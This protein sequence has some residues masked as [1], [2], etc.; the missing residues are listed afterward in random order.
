MSID[1]LKTCYYEFLSYFIP[2]KVKYR[3]EGE[4]IKCG[5]CCRQIRAYG[6]KNEK[7]LKLIS[8][9]IPLYKN[10]YITGYDENGDLILSCKH[11]QDN[12]L[13]AIYNKR[14]LFCKNFPAKI[15]DKNVETIDGCGFKVI[16][17]KFSDYL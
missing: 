16:K 5:N 2:K 7:E 3:V 11:I 15:I 6:L 9:F 1:F 14:P 10:F 17:K 4:C 8:F 12:N 13:C